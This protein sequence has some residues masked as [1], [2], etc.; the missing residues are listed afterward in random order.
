MPDLGSRKDTAALA[1]G[2]VTVV[3]W[4]SAFVGIRAAGT[5]LRRTSAGRSGALNYLIP[6]VAVGLGWVLLD[7]APPWPAL[8]GGMVCLG[9]VY[10]ARVWKTGQQTS[11]TRPDSSAVSNGETR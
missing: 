6:V 9:G 3:L 4:G 8:A 7:E 2:L 10:L 11:V 1:A 5:A